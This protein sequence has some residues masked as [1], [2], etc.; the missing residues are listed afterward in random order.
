[1][2]K[3][4][5]ENKIVLIIDDANPAPPSADF[6]FAALANSPYAN[7][8]IYSDQ[9]KLA[10]KQQNLVDLVVA[11]QRDAQITVKLSDDKMSATAKIVCAWGGEIVS[12]DKAKQAIVEQKV[13]RG[14][15]QAW[16]DDLL[17]KQFSANPG[18]EFEAVIAQG[19]SPVAGKDGY[20]EKHV[21]TLGERIRSPKRNEDGSVD[22]RD[23]G[24]LASV[25][26]DTL[27]MTHHFATL[28]QDGFNVIGETLKPVAGKE[29]KLKAGSGTYLS[30]NQTQLFAEISGVPIDENDGL[31]VDDIFTIADVDVKSGHIDFNGSVVITHNVSAGMKVIANGDITIMG[32][33]ESAEL[34]ATGNI[35]IKQ[36]CVGHQ[37]K[38]GS[39]LSC[40]IQSK[41]NVHTKHAQY[42]A[43]QAN[44]ISIDTMASHCQLKAKNNLIIGDRDKR[45]GKLIGGKVLDAKTLVCAEI[46]TET[47]A[48]TIIMLDH[49]AVLLKQKVDDIFKKVTDSQQQIEKL[50]DEFNK[51]LN[52]EDAAQQQELLMQI[53][54][55]QTHLEQ[56]V[57][58]LPLKAAKLESAIATL[59]K[60]CYLDVLGAMHSNV[61]LHIFTKV[62]KT[63]RSYPPL[64]ARLVDNKIALDFKTT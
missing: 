32:S 44:N 38:D 2:F 27:L 25:T 6:V 41:G 46:G 36:G 18:D 17:G 12:L 9:V 39:S 24:K 61:E 59:N 60:Y 30:S 35:E 13:T 64:I 63:N 48:H 40:V 57:E 49:S 34:I 4:N 3:R 62:L 26:P 21:A 53:S 7:C 54:D 42:C 22:M 23:F 14:F 52:I 56:L 58:L 51:A 45:S 31:R 11:E 29:C 15:K 19:K 50:E 16:L 20:L 5:T 37:L 10:F 28:G 1:M 55:K 47:G 8:F 33:V 43:I